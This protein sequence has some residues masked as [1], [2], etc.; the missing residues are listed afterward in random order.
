MPW[1]MSVLLLVPIGATAFIFWAY[2]KKIAQK[3]AARDERYRQLLAGDPQTSTAAAVT[4]PSGKTE[5][6]VSASPPLSLQSAPAYSRKER[7]LSPRENLLYYV[8][9]AG[10]PD[11]EIFAH[12]DLSAVVEVPQAMRGYERE[13]HQRRLARY[14]VDFVVCDKNAN[15]VAAAEFEA[16]DEYAAFKTAC[17]EKAGIRRVPIN[18]AAIP[19]RDAIRRLVYGA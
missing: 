7:L 19:K 2:Q 8:L 12:V 3:N 1:L 18:P 10:L 15:I 16:N 6:A 11:H 14:R 4:P 5:T 9:K 13:Q 17:L